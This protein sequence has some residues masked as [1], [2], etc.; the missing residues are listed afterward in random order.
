MFP[1]GLECL[2]LISPIIQLKGSEA[3]AH[4]PGAKLELWAYCRAGHIAVMMW[5]GTLFTT[6]FSRKANRREK[7]AV[8][9]RKYLDAHHPSK[10]CKGGVRAA[11]R[12]R[13]NAS[14]LVQ[15]EVFSSIAGCAVGRGGHHVR[16]GGLSGD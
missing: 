15:T 1:S 14:Y 2:R 3:A 9:G 12:E 7:E 8:S 10:S 6:R 13:K 16:R 4:S 11:G 5:A